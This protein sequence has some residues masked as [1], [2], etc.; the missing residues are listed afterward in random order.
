MVL[1]GEV[2]LS[3]NSC[4]GR[5]LSLRIA[6]KGEIL[7]L[8]SVLSGGLSSEMTAEM[9]YPQRLRPSGGETFSTFF[10]IIPRFTRQ[11]GRNEPCNTKW[12]ASNCAPWRCRL[13]LLKNWPACC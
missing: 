9:L 3:I 4:D 5:R 6:R 8:S 12:L 10:R 13:Q 11:Y 1:E 7:G 2:K